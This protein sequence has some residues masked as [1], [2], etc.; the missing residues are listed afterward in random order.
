M[1]NELNKQR[2][3]RRSKMMIFIDLDN[4]ADGWPLVV[5]NPKPPFSVKMPFEIMFVL[6]KDRKSKIGA[7]LTIDS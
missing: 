5:S 4:V 6:V 2:K 1:L 3:Y 7:G